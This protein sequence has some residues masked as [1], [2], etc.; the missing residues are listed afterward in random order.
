MWTN[1]VIVRE[2]DQQVMGYVVVSSE[3]V[4]LNAAARRYAPTTTFR[5][6]PWHEATLDQQ[7]Q[8]STANRERDEAETARQSEARRAEFEAL[9]QRHDHHTP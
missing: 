8:A 4:A 1:Y 7:Q 9:R 2:P 3:Q 5:A 6:I